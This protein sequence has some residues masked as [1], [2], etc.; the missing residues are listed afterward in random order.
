[1]NAITQYWVMVKKQT[2]ASRRALFPLNTAS[3]ENIKIL[4]KF[5]AMLKFT[6]WT[7]QRA[8]KNY[9]GKY[10]CGWNHLL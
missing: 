3:C 9:I 2:E 10:G 1:M 6:R 8:K 5:L 4:R 7:P